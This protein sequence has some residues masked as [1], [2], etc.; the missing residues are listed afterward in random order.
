[1]LVI[2]L[3]A[4]LAFAFAKRFFVALACVTALNIRVPSLFLA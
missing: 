1:M 4:T 3:L 2:M